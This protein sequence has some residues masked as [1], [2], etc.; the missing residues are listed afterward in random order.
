MAT[1]LERLKARRRGNR[2]VVTKLIEEA[3]AILDTEEITDKGYRRLK[4][5]QGQLEG[6]ETLLAELDEQ[7]LE[8]SDIADIETDILQSNEI[9]CSITEITDEIRQ[10]TE[11]SSPSER[12]EPA[13]VET[14]R[15][16]SSVRSSPM[17]SPSLSPTPS[18]H[19]ERS[20]SRASNTPSVIMGGVKPKLPKL[21]IAKF[22]GDVTKF[23][24]FWDSFDSA[25]NQ[26]P[27]LSAIDKFNYLQGLLD[28]PAA[29]AIQGLTLSEANYTTALALLKERFGKTQQVISAH[30]DQLLRLPSCIGD[31][32]SQ[33]RAIYD[34]I[35]VQVRGLDALGVR[36]EQYGSFLIPVIMSKL[37]AEI[38]LQIARVTTQEVWNIE[39]LLRVI[40]GEVEARELSEGIK[41]QETKKS[42]TLNRGAISTASA[43]VVRE[44]SGSQ[45]KVCVYCKGEHYLASCEKVKEVATRKD[46][47][48]K[49]G[50]CFLC[51]TNGHRVSN[52]SSPQ[53]CRRCGRK[54]HQ[55]LCTQNTADRNTDTASNANLDTTTPTT[56]CT[57]RS[58]KTQTA[59]T[60]AYTADE[61][62][63]PIRMLMDNGSQ[64]SYVTDKLKSQLQLKPIKRER[65]VLN[66]FGNDSFQKRKCEQ[67]EVRLQGRY[68]EDVV[69][70]AATFPT[71]CSP[72]QTMVEVDQYQHLQGLDLADCNYSDH[73]T[74]GNNIDMSDFYWDVVIGDLVRAEKGPVAVSSKFGW[75]L[76]GPMKVNQSKG[77]FVISNMIIEGI[78]LE[79]VQASSDTNVVEALQ[80]FWDTE[81][82]GINGAPPGETL[83]NFPPSITFDWK[84]ERYRICLPWKSTLRPSTDAY[85]MCRSRLYQLRNRLKRDDALLQEYN[86]VF[87][88]QLADGIIEVVT[89]QENKPGNQYFIPHHGVV[90]RDKETTKLRVVFD[91]SA[92]VSQGEL[93]LNECLEKGQNMTP[94]IFEILLRFRSHLIGI[95]ADIEKAFHQ[96]VIDEIF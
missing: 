46:V 61:K 76:S 30:M 8:V 47:L 72:L 7:I 21:H 28:G 93:S 29:A 32:A 53:R 96:I 63:V 15:D 10:Q 82:I 56:T 58:V 84:Q 16:D 73:D 62:L 26:N 1:D 80:R 50:R 40:K 90:R 71:I 41:I 31:K 9:L 5:I 37:P 12:S 89:A 33:I 4:V 86:L 34:K 87:Q 75:L 36:A 6:K 20:E 55:S 45:K 13:T 18:R 74:S 24:T 27:S 14:N 59:H 79:E 52:C 92:R 60:F 49:E 43:L 51:L 69:I 3:R 67:I 38:R 83:D 81:N 64:R 85:H 2:A 22:S 42:E 95:I 17:R 19:E 78:E 39:E 94:H 25:V 23:R 54:H 35:S 65:I 44:T 48:R 70:T 11:R 91:G 68:E 66:T 77:D 88:K 57:A